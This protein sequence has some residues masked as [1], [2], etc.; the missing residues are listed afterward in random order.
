MRRRRDSNRPSNSS[1]D[2]IHQSTSPETKLRKSKRATNTTP[3]KP[4]RLQPSEPLHMTTRA[5]SKA[6]SGSSG[7]IPSSVTSSNSRR[8]SL[9][10]A[11]SVHADGEDAEKAT[12]SRRTSVPNGPS[13]QKEIQVASPTKSEPNGTIV[14]ESTESLGPRKR[15]RL[16]RSAANGSYDKSNGT[17]SLET[18]INTFIDAVE[19]RL[20]LPAPKRRGRRKVLELATPIDSVEVSPGPITP[21]MMGHGT[22]GPSA[23]LDLVDPSGEEPN[24][25]VKRLPGRRRAPHANISIEADLRR[26]LQLK[27][28]YRSVAKALKPLLAELAQRTIDEVENDPE[29]HKRSDEYEV[30]QAELDARLRER[31]KTLNDTYEIKSQNLKSVME[32]EQTIKRTETEIITQNLQDQYISKCKKTLLEL[33]RVVN[34][35][36]EDDDTDDEYGIIPPLLSAARKSQPRKPLSSIYDSR[37]RELIEV[38]RLWNETEQRLSTQICL[39]SF[40]DSTNGELDDLM[41]QKPQSFATYDAQDRKKATDAWALDQNLI[42]LAEAG[43]HVEEMVEKSKDAA[44]ALELLATTQP[45]IATPITKRSGSRKKTGSTKSTPARGNTIIASSSPRIADVV[46]SPVRQVSTTL[47]DALI[48]KPVQEAPPTLTVEADVVTNGNLPSPPEPNLT[49]PYQ[50]RI[51]SLLN[52]DSETSDEPSVTSKSLDTS[53]KHPSSSSPSKSTPRRVDLETPTSTTVYNTPLMENAQ[54]PIQTRNEE[55]KTHLGESADVCKQIQ[56]IVREVQF[57]NRIEDTSKSTNAGRGFWATLTTKTVRPTSRSKEPSPDKGMFSK[58]R[59]NFRSREASPEKKPAPQR[60]RQLAEPSERVLEEERSGMG[61][62]LLR[63]S[64]ERAPTRPTSTST[65]AISPTTQNPLPSPVGKHSRSQSHEFGHRSLAWDQFRRSTISEPQQHAHHSRTP[66]SGPIPHEPSFQRRT[67]YDYERHRPQLPHNDFHPPQPPHPP[68]SPYQTSPAA[69]TFPPPRQQQPYVFPRFQPTYSPQPNY[70]QPAF[71]QSPAFA[72][73]PSINQYQPPL[74]PPPAP[75]PHRQPA[76]PLAPAPP[77]NPYPTYT[78]S[79]WQTQPP[80]SSP[81]PATTQYSNRQFGGQPILPAN[82]N[83]GNAPAQAQPAFAQHQYTPPQ[84]QGP[85]QT[86]NH[87]TNYYPRRK[88]RGGNDR[89]HPP[90]F[91]HFRGPRQNR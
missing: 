9:A 26:Q 91:R 57:D 8:S 41:C 35:Q 32:I 11:K 12:K 72:Q 23:S 69:T 39:K 50:T 63:M 44:A 75:H 42:R 67:S 62:P 86:N 51:M 13:V 80:P 71:S 49:R 15:K 64:E 5:A 61:P 78:P 68:P 2:T 27:T 22:P 33:F 34:S 84:P 66:S 31:L 18:S 83:P 30:V 43:S 21:I 70:Q 46:V 36:E 59:H 4:S 52:N 3:A 28:S 60:E 7:S 76:P 10:S 1:Q 16:S 20:E 79:S 87:T 56:G 77:Q 88:N 73:G 89:Y 19:E 29:A 65:S 82:L 37:S 53:L 25:L 45:V 90:E 24:K 85:S 38:E 54:P 6:V 81:Y 74:P 14:V 40:I 58:F 48:S 17:N 55:Q 47:Q